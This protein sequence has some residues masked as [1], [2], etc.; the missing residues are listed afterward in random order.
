M[1]SSRTK[2]LYWSLVIGD[3]KNTRS[4]LNWTQTTPRYHAEHSQ[5]DSL[6][7]RWTLSTWQLGTTLNT[8]NMTAWYHAEHSQHDTSVPRWTL[9]TWQLGTMMHSLTYSDRIMAWLVLLLGAY[10]KYK[11]QETDERD[12]MKHAWSEHKHVQCGSKVSQ[13]S[14]KLATSNERNRDFMSLTIKPRRQSVSNSTL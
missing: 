14:V 13:R 8:L 5:H 11:W 10:C 3:I 6:V 4:R 12:M 7:P 1:N 9:S 2:N